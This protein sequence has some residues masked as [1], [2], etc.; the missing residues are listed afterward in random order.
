M[1]RI[2]AATPPRSVLSC[3]FFHLSQPQQSPKSQIAVGTRRRFPPTHAAYLEQPRK[4]NPGAAA[5][6]LSLRS[7]PPLPL[8]HTRPR[9]NCAHRSSDPKAPQKDSPVECCANPSKSR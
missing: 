8:C 6:S 3:W 7:P 2:S 4:E 9:E 5:T 1:F